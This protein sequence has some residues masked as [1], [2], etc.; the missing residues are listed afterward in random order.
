[1]RFVF[2]GIFARNPVG[3]PSLSLLRDV[4]VSARHS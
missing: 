2:F 4:V 1:M 3:M